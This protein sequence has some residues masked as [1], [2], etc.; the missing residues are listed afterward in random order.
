MDPTHHQK[1]SLPTGLGML[2]PELLR[3][4]FECY[5]LHC[6]G[7]PDLPFWSIRGPTNMEPTEP[8]DSSTYWQGRNT[9]H[10]LC[11]VSRRF[12]YIAQDIL[13]HEFIIPVDVKPDPPSLH[14]RLE[15]FLRT[16]ATR[17]N[18]ARRVHT[19]ALDEYVSDDLDVK[20]AREAFEEALHALGTNPAR[21]WEPRKHGRRVPVSSVSA[22]EISR[23][24]I[25][26]E[27]QPSD[28]TNVYAKRLVVV[29]ILALLL[30]LLPNLHHLILRDHLLPQQVFPK[31]VGAL[32][33]T[34]IPLQT[35]DAMLIPL[36]ILAIA[37]DLKTIHVC[38]RTSYPKM[39]SVKGVYFQ[40]YGS[41][42][43]LCVQKI[44]SSS[45]KSLSRFS[46]QTYFVGYSI[47]RSVN[48]V[49][50]PR[51]AVN[52]L[53]KVRST[54][55][56]LHLDMRFR[57]SF[58]EESRVK[59]I[60][61][62]KQFTALE[63]LFLTTNSVYNG[64]S[65]ISDEESL[66]HL[67]PQSIESVT[68]VDH[69]FPPQPDRLRRGFLGL[70]EAKGDDGQFPNLKLLR[71][72]SKPICEDEKIRHA[73]SQVGVDFKYQEFPT[74]HWSYSRDPLPPR[75]PLPALEDDDSE[76]D[77]DLPGLV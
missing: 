42:D 66:V 69:E 23:G 17:P 71:Y 63:E 38:P 14:R 43:S 64:T 67:L 2:A 24:F 53:T 47:D 61:S 52:L 57:V 75:S 16:L 10:S 55:R 56:S 59:P 41:D 12:R 1:Q 25:L 70:A 9:L 37:P 3:R 62:L 45:S 8:S 49:L 5:C 33:L 4:I 72:D 74:R 29:E 20:Y 58:N 76:F 19:V 60:P 34:R 6:H 32:G 13:F 31:A 36:S 21:F 68:F 44:L 35:L 73:F 26:G 54:L 51:T 30:T 65:T 50:Q 18:L 39:R 46:Y 48:E 7:R 27:L 28:M 77:E 11:L 15:P 40:G 22:W